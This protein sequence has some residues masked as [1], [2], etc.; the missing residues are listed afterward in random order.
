MN[1][2]VSYITERAKLLP[3]AS[4]PRVTSSRRSIRCRGRPAVRERSARWAK[5][6]SL[7]HR[8]LPQQHDVSWSMAAHLR[9]CAAVEPATRPAVV[10]SDDTGA[11]ILVLAGVRMTAKIFVSKKVRTRR[12]EKAVSTNQNTAPAAR[13]LSPVT[14]QNSSHCNRPVYICLRRPDC[15]KD[16]AVAY[17]VRS[18]TLLAD[19]IETRNCLYIGYQSSQRRQRYHAINHCT[20]AGV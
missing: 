2:G 18:Y 7:P 12:S 1:T 10:S 3:P 6:T 16:T 5:T 19:S 20:A 8:S 14:M 9:C 4:D 17:H 11:I 15:N 13:D